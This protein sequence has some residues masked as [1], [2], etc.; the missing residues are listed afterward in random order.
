[1]PRSRSPVRRTRRAEPGLA[2]RLGGFPA[3]AG[4]D[5]PGL[6]RRPRRAR[7]D[8][9]QQIPGVT[10]PSPKTSYHFNPVRF[11]AADLARPHGVDER[12]AAAGYK[13]QIRFFMQLIRKRLR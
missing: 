13:D 11:A 3:P 10:R 4:D 2:G 5:P 1:M 9:R 12:I 6:P 8:G 7:I